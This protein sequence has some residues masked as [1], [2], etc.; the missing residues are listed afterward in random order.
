MDEPLNLKFT[1]AAF[2]K[3]ISFTWVEDKWATTFTHHHFA[4]FVPLI[5]KN[6][7]KTH[8]VCGKVYYCSELKNK[9]KKKKPHEKQGISDRSMDSII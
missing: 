8:C 4:A 7:I 3:T 1:T 2:I 5:F 6:T 9:T